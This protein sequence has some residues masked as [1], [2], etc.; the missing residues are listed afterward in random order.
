[1]VCA[2]YLYLAGRSWT[3]TWVC[4][5]GLLVNAG[6]NATLIRPLLAALGPGGAG[7]G[8]A[9]ATIGT[10]LFT[11]GMFACM[12][13]RNVID[14]RLLA[15]AG[16]LVGSCAAVIAVD[17]VCASFGSVRLVFDAVAYCALAVGTG[18]VRVGELL[19]FV[20]AAR[21]SRRGEAC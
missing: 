3:V 5:G 1:M 11:C 19:D 20:N 6:L 2:D 8:G 18:A 12:I 7:V 21:K 14:R 15:T 4:V 16:K 10:E 9:L 13:G 17:H